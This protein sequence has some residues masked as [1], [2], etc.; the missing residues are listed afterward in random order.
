MSAVIEIGEGAKRRAKSVNHVAALEKL[1]RRIGQLSSLPGVA[2]RIIEVADDEDS[3]AED[4]LKVVEQDPTLAVRIMRTVNSTFFGLHQEV[5]DLQTAV[6]MLGFVEVRKLALTVCVARLCEE[7]S[8]YHSFSREG[9]WKHMVTVAEISRLV[10]EICG[11]GKPEE[12]YMAGLLHDIG[13]VPDR[14]VHAHAAPHGHRHDRGRHAACRKRS[15]RCSR[16]TTP[17][18]GRTS[19]ARATSR[20]GSSRRLSSTTIPTASGTE[21]GSCWTSSRSPIAW[22]PSTGCFVGARHRAGD[23]GTGLQRGWLWRGAA[24][25]DYREAHRNASR[26]RRPCGDL[27]A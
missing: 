12:A 16:S 25:G 22:P 20:S 2:Q 23:V 1:F 3:T 26:R 17:T 27:K 10:S 9:L 5:A 11:C 4:L 19:P 6:S 13:L 14:P 7:N 21:T 18:W 24:Q 8:S 15:R